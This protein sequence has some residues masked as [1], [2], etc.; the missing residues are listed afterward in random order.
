MGKL[1]KGGFARKCVFP[2]RAREND[3]NPSDEKLCVNSFSLSDIS[4]KHSFQL[5]NQIE[6]STILQGKSF[7]HKNKTAIS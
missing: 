4:E 5:E 7:L 6:Y 1:E 2:V 3:K